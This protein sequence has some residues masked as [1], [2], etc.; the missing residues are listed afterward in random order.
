MRRT[1]TTSYHPQANGLVERFHR[2][3]KAAIKCHDSVDW[4]ATLPI[5]LLGIRTSVKEDL[6]A[7]TAE[8]VYG[9]GL[10]LPAEFFN[11]NDMNPSSD[12]FDDLK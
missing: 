10:R 4:V 7:T 2:Q 12:Y 9:T 3:L 6:G 5:V 11:T 1:R 8:L